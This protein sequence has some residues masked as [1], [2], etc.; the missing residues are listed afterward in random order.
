MEVARTRL[1]RYDELPNLQDRPGR[2]PFEGGK[3]GLL[4][5]KHD[6]YHANEGNQTTRKGTSPQA[7]RGVEVAMAILGV[8]PR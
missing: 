2:T 5:R 6:H 8:L 1:A 3:A 7:P 4:I